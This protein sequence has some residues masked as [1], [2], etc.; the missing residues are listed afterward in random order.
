[1]YSLCV[2][3]PGRLSA[4]RDESG[5]RGNGDCWEGGGGGRQEAKALPPQVSNPGLVAA[6]GGT[7]RGGERLPGESQ[8]APLRKDESA[9]EERK[10]SN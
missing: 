7:E 3:E 5:E 2:C 4:D 8:E 6:G 10:I 9:K 1:M